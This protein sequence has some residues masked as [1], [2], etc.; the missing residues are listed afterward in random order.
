MSSPSLRFVATSDWHFGRRVPD[1]ET[2]QQL[3]DSMAASSAEFCA[4]FRG[5]CRLASTG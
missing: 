2:L 1:V 4:R 3:I 5:L